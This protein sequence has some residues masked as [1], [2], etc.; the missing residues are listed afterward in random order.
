VGRSVIKIDLILVTLT[1]T[2]VVAAQSVRAE[3]QARGSPAQ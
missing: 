1:A 3:T 2:F